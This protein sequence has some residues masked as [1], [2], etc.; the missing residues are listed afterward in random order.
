MDI[1]HTIKK[2][3]AVKGALLLMAY[4]VGL[5]LLVNLTTSNP[6]LGLYLTAGLAGS[7]YL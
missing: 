3:E 2:A 5:G 1:E 4:L 6:D 7:I